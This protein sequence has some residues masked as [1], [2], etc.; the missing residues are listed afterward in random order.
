MEIAKVPAGFSNGHHFRVGRGVIGAGDPV[1]AFGHHVPGLHD[2][3]TER[4]ALVTLHAEA[5]KGDGFPQVV[6]ILLLHV[7]K[8][9]AG[10]YP[11][12]TCQR[13]P[14]L[15]LTEAL[16]ME[17]L[18]PRKRL[19]FTGE[20]GDLFAVLIVNW[21]LTFIT[22]G[23]YY[24]WAKARRLQYF[25]EH[26]ELDA[27]PLH[28]HGTGKEMFIG[29]IKAVGLFVLIYA[30][31]FGLFM[32]QEIWAMV[33]GY[34][35]LFVAIIALTPLII[36]GTYRYRMGRSSW[37]GIHFGYR[38]DLKELYS[39]CIRDGLLTLITFGIY[40]AWFQMNLR[41]YVLGHVRF[42]NSSFHYKGDGLDFFLM[43]LKGYFLT[44]FTLGIYS[45]WWQRD[46]F[47]YYVNNLSWNFAE[48]RR[49]QFKSTA[50]GGGFF[51]LI[52]VNA[53]LV[54]F[55]LG[56]GLAWAHVRMM[57]FVMANIEMV[58]DADLDAVVQTEQ[59]HRN[60]TADELGDIMD[61]GIFL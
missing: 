9:F 39:L 20:G 51:E 43:N 34:V 60:A 50:T 33:L 18:T 11:G 58:G 1:V 54:I 2:Q 26:T 10:R 44:I 46:I 8:L 38:G 49:I 53:L 25:Y 30:V 48:G 29:F 12:I 28:F 14:I 7:A 16:T 4:T 61:I 35:F 37:R 19:S 31:F 6:F 27:H 24:P 47:N 42:G 32:T 57:K 22:L 36:H 17:L 59:E 52:V 21:L 40:G 55:T 15:P 5:R 45:F 3:A 13:S 56:I 41:N 23:I